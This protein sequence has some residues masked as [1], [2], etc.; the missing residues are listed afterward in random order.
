MNTKP[1]Y[2]H[3][4]NDQFFKPTPIRNNQGWCK[5]RGGM[6]ASRKDDEFGWINWCRKEEFHLED[7]ETSF[8]FTLR[9]GARVLLLS[10]PDQLDILPKTDDRYEK[11]NWSRTC[12]LDFVALMKDYDAVELTKWYRFQWPLY[13][14]D[15][16][17]ILIMNPD[18]VEVIEK[19]G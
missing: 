17:C 3:Y 10:D 6:W 5:P 14:W 8:E 11:G 16:N 18:I 2:I 12:N 9:D 7:L 4:G 13:S 15:C 19:G 1:V